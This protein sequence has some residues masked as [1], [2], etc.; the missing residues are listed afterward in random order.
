MN[1]LYISKLDG[2]PWM[3]PTY[4]VPNQV[5]AQSKYDNVFWYNLSNYGEEEGK[6]Y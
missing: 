2:R 5:K 3:G 4:S 1:I 6:K